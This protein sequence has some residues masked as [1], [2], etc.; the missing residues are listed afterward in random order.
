MANCPLHI[1]HENLTLSYDKT[2][3]T[4]YVVWTALIKKIYSSFFF[5]LIEFTSEISILVF[6]IIGAVI[7]FVGRENMNQGFSTMIQLIAIFLVL[8]STLL[9][10]GYTLAVLI[11]AAVGLREILKFTAIRKKISAEY[12]TIQKE[13]EQ[14]A[15]RQRRIHE[16]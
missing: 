5:A 8:F 9:N 7:K 3:Y 6:V 11:K 15:A 14:K 4:V 1:T 10:L 12:E 13:K 2:L 16:K